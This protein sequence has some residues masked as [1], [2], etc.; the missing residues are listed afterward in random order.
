MAKQSGMG[1]FL[2]VDG[3]DLSGDVG[4]VQTMRAPCNALDVTSISKSAYERIHGL[5]DGEIS[6]NS[7]FNDAASQEHL[8]LKAKG[9]GANRVVSYFHGAAL[10]GMAAGLVAKQVNYDGARGA[11]GSLVF[12]IQCLGNGFGL[13][14][15]GGGGTLAAADGQLTAGK[16][17]HASATNGSGLD[18]GIV[19]GTAFGLAAYGQFFSLGSGT[20]TVKIQ[21]STDDGA[22]DP[23][24]DVSGATF[25]VVTA[26]TAARVVTSLTASIERWLRVVSTGTFT[27]LVL[28][29]NVSRYPVD[30]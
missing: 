1:D 27:N 12:T 11:D 16:V 8:T 24:A 21:S 10:G 13:D 20:P 19:G 7:F 29:V 2:Y 26:P 17:T 15:S 30:D 22:G 14:H 5:F 25:G 18:S 3:V 9:S 4:A 28:A 23:Y 6:F